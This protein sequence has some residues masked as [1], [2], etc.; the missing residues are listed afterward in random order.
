[1][2]LSLPMAARWTAPDPR[3][4]A[5]RGQLTVERGPLVLSLESMDIAGRNVADVRVDLDLRDDAG[6]VTVTVRDLAAEDGAWPYGSGS[7]K[8]GAGDTRAELRPYHSWGNRGPSTMRVWLPII[9]A[10]VEVPQPR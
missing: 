6:T 8:V 10:D 1:M 5:L 3:I 9:G 7:A 2:E 4:D